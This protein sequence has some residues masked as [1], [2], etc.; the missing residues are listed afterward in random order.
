MGGPIVSYLIAGEELAI[1]TVQ[2]DHPPPGMTGRAL[3][4]PGAA[5]VAALFALG[6]AGATEEV[7][8]APPEES[9]IPLVFSIAGPRVSFDPGGGGGEPPAPIIVEDE[10]P[11]DIWVVAQRSP[12]IFF[13]DGESYVPTL[14]EDAPPPPVVVLRPP[15]LWVGAANDELS[16]VAPTLHEDAGQP[17]QPAPPRAHAPPVWGADEVVAPKLM[18]E[19]G[20]T[21][22]PVVVRTPVLAM[23]WGADDEI[24]SATIV[25]DDPWIALPT[26]PRPMVRVLETVDDWPATSVTLYPIT[27]KTGPALLEPMFGPASHEPMFG[28]A[29]KE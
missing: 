11:P 14:S 17:Y 27:S 20:P 25:D 16:V 2:E 15:T 3:R 7:V 19:P 10:A 9:G 29:L 8:S 22:P 26:P 13:W 21:L 24:S 28:H 18:E 4:S 1:V 12:T 5:A 23:A 6:V